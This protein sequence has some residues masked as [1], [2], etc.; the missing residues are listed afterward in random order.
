M[1][2]NQEDLKRFWLFEHGW[3]ISKPTVRIIIKSFVFPELIISIFA[4]IEHPQ[5]VFTVVIAAPA[6]GG[7]FNSAFCR[8][9]VESEIPDLAGP[10][11][12]A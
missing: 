9:G 2:K 8:S 5:P 11:C 10:T 7:D 4:N 1:E 12:T 3:M 6:G